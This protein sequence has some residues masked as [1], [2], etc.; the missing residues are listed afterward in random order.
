MAFGPPSM[1][2]VLS[3]LPA[4][5]VLVIAPHPDD[6]MVGPGGTLLRHADQGDPIHAVI[7]FD[8]SLGDPERYYEPRDYVAL[9]QAESRGVLRDFLGCEDV[10]F[11]GFVD[12]VTEGNV[13]A[14]YPGLPSDPDEK[15]RVLIDGLAARLEAE[16]ERVS[17]RSLY[18][19]WIGE[20]HA[21]HWGCAAAVR[22]LARNRRDLLGEVA[23]L[24]YEVWSTLLP[25][26]LVDVSAVFARKR[27]AIARYVSQGRYVDLAGVVAGMNRYRA[28]LLPYVGPGGE[29]HAEAFVGLHPEEDRP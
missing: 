8:G 19:P 29:R 7:V 16:I 2:R 4:G 23:L 24:G 6:E 1:P 17:P 28:M 10:V 3:A 26:F 20:V 21:D 27:E 12:G 22:Q 9:R 14:I 25:E 18:Y 5:P 11:F 13:D 15:R